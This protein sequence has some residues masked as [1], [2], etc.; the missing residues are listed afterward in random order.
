[1]PLEGQVDGSLE[2]LRLLCSRVTE[3]HCP[4]FIAR[5]KDSGALS[6]ALHVL[7]MFMQAQD[8]CPGSRGGGAFSPLVQ[9]V[10]PKGFGVALSTACRWVFKFMRGDGFVFALS[11]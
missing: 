11:R 9:P 1:M 7:L 6:V 8:S 5:K 4:L 2:R 10:T 3:R